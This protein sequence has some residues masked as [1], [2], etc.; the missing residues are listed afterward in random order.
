MATLRRVSPAPQPSG[1]RVWHVGCNV[2]APTRTIVDMARQTSGAHERAHW[3]TVHKTRDPQSFAWYQE[4]PSISI[5]LILS[6]GADLNSPVIDIGGGSS[7]LVDHLLDAGYT[8]LTVL[9]ISEQALA[10]AK[11]RLSLSGDAVE[12]IAADV[13]RHPFERTYEVWHDRAAFHFLTDADG[14][15]R[16]VDQMRAS[17]LVGGVAIVATFSPDGPEQCSGLPVQRYSEETLSELLGDGFRPLRFERE[18][19]ATPQG[20]VQHF[21]YGCYQRQ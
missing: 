5:E 2:A 9:D 6:F 1:W 18:A 21:V 7:L 11:K 4:T 10:V 14:Q 20:K 15:Q 12:W 16:Y 19:H 13:T 17:L 3:Q 8:D